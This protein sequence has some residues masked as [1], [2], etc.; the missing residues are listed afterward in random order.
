MVLA[1]G[2]KTKI[3]REIG[4]HPAQNLHHFIQQIPTQFR[5]RPTGAY[6]SINVTEKNAMRVHLLLAL[7]GVKK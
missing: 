2:F 4:K 7:N 3:N 5:L 6:A 1:A